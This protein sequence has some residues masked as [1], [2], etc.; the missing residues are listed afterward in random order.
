LILFCNN[1]EVFCNN[2][3]VKNPKFYQLALS[4]SETLLT[5]DEQ[6]IVIGNDGGLIDRPVAVTAPETLRLSM[7]ERYEVI[8][9]FSKYPIGTQLYLQNTGLKATVD[10]KTAVN[11][12]MR[13]DVVRQAP[14]DSEIPTILRPF[15]T[16]S[17]S[18]AA[19]NRTFRYENRDG[20]WTIND[21]VWDEN[22]IDATVNPGDIEIWTLISKR[23]SCIQYTCTSL[24]DRS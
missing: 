16:I 19:R 18:Q 11:P 9:D 4:R 7:A 22:R 5:P 12:I 21:R 8:I 3:E 24:K 20:R 6:L 10:F 13:F 15:E 1:T 14:D 17:V 2:T 23:G